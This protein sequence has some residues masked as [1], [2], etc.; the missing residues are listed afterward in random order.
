MV[1]RPIVET[2]T[3]ICGLSRWNLDLLCIGVFVLVYSFS[4]LRV[5]DHS[6]SCLVHNKLCCI[7][8]QY[9]RS[10]IVSLV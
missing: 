4:G 7:C 1:S 2:N 10:E 6:V 3:D 9:N 5:R 8:F